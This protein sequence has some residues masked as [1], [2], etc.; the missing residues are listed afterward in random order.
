MSKLVAIRVRNL[1]S[2]EDTGFIELKPITILVGKNS[3]GKSTFARLLPLLRQT[4]EVQKKEPILWWGRF[5]DFGSFSDSVS[6]NSSAREIE[7]TFKVLIEDMLGNKA[8]I[9]KG[10]KSPGSEELTEVEAGIVLKENDATHESYLARVKIKQGI[11][12]YTIDFD[13]S[14]KLVSIKVNDFS[15]DLSSVALTQVVLASIFPRIEFFKKRKV[16]L[17]DNSTGEVLYSADQIK[18]ELLRFFSVAGLV[19]GNTGWDTVLDIIR[20]L[21][22]SSIE[23]LLTS[24]KGVVGA[25]SS[26]RSTV[27]NLNKNNQKLVDLRNRILASGILGMLEQIDSVLVSAVS[28]CSYIEP[29]RATAERYYRKQGLSVAEVDSK[30][31]NVPFFLESLTRGDRDQFESWM[32]AHLKARVRTVPDGGGHLVILLKEKSGI[33]VNLADVGFGFSQVLPVALQLWAASRKKMRKR[34]APNANSSIVVIEQPE[35]HLHPEYQAKIADLIKSTVDSGFVNVIVETHS[36][37]IINRLGFLIA[38]EKLDRGMIQ[39]LRFEKDETSTSTFISTS[40]FDSD[41]V[42]QDWPYGFFDI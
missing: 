25:P 1:R 31:A 15:P 7:L 36:P 34:I 10:W 39:V 18:F 19:H 5:V 29:L 20:Q 22:V 2:L 11:D 12:E 21:D 32:E 16:A 37:S 38:T 28:S 13:N 30:G 40:S 26:W 33:E 23:S 14:Q 4:A 6:K 9:L 42:L 3:A 27:D 24:M 8:Y 17:P 41:G 35:L